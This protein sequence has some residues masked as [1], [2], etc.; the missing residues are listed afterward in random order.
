MADITYER[1]DIDAAE[2][3]L[4]MGIGL[5]ERTR[6]VGELV[7]GYVTL[8]KVKRA[9]G[10][11]EGALEAAREAER[12]ARTS[13]ANLQIS[14]AA[15]WTARL[16]IARGDLELTAALEQERATNTASGASQAVDRL[17]SARLLLARGRHDETLRLLRELREAAEAAG[18]TGTLI[19]ILSLQAMALWASNEKEQGVEILTQ[20]LAMAEPEG[21]VRTFVDEGATMAD[22]LAATLEARQ[23]SHPDSA[24]R[25]PARYLAK[26]LAALDQ[27]SA[28]LASD[29]RLTEPLSEREL[30][31]LALIAAGETNGE[32]AGKLFV[33]IS[34]VKTHINNLY[35]KLGAR[36]RT[37][38]VARARELGLL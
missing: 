25:V 37:R 1:D 23:K 29:G 17:T 6:E 32:I 15:A 27:A 24:G 11:E 35:R 30:E 10:D 20:A 19:E 36:S 8:S 9:R 7:R 18:R 33:S 31:V 3:E 13:G 28:A 14:I 26:L 5:I 21:Y 34:T 38:A 16:H 4:E 22:L 2:R 12:V